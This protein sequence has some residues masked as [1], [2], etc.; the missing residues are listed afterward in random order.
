MS[1]E[2]STNFTRWYVVVTDTDFE[3]RPS[4]PVVSAYKTD[5]EAFT[6]A[7]LVEHPDWGWAEVDVQVFFGVR[8]TVN[9]E[10]PRWVA[11]RAAREAALKPQKAAAVVEQEARDR[12]ELARLKAK[13]EP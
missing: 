5:E 2:D 6:A 12:A 10:D 11:A 4:E 3:H 7:A 9:D 1:E 13:Y 8:V